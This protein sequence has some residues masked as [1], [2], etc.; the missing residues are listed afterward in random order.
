MS[1]QAVSDVE[2]AFTK[3]L[4]RLPDLYARTPHDEL[5]RQLA[6]GYAGA[7]GRNHL[8]NY[9]AVAVVAL[10]DEQAVGAKTLDNWDAMAEMRSERY[11][12]AWQNAA[13]RARTHLMCL[14]EAEAEVRVLR[15][16]LAAR[17]DEVA[18]LVA[19]LAEYSGLAS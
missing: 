13:Q 7:L 11:R 1:R 14:R 16:G 2:Q 10:L 9:L 19:R 3:A 15:A 18:E 6:T 8:A 4:S 17:E 12:L 5:V